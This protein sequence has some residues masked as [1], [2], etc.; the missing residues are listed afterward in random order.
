MSYEKDKSASIID[1]MAVIHST[2]KSGLETFADLDKRFESSIYSSLQESNIVVL[3]PDRYDVEFSIKSDERSTLTCLIVGGGGG[4]GGVNSGFWRIFWR[5]FTP[6]RVILCFW[7][8]NFR[9]CHPF[10]FI[11]PPPPTIRQVRVDTKNRNF[12]KFTKIA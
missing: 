11:R 9:K 4:G 7:P 1:F 8:I 6:C 10:Q 5:I 12:T 3:V 2:S